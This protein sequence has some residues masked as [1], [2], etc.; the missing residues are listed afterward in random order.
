MQALIDA[1]GKGRFVE[2]SSPSK[3]E[4]LQQLAELIEGVDPRLREVDVLAAVTAREQTRKTGLGMGWACPHA[5]VPGDLPLVS[6]IGWS[7]AGIDYGSADG[8]KVHM[9]VMYV[10]PEAQKNSYLKDISTLAKRLWND[11]RF[12]F[13]DGI[14]DLD[15]MHRH[16]VELV[17]APYEPLRIDAC[18]RAPRDNEAPALRAPA[19]PVPSMLPLSVLSVPGVKSVVLALDR[20]LVTTLENTPDLGRTLDRHGQADVGGFRVLVRSHSK[21]AQDR[22]LYEC[23][24]IRSTAAPG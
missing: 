17:G 18:A 9:V 7:R 19:A 16:V 23:L 8:R 3:G 20:T 13:L 11:T 22:T 21:F 12:Q 15:E 10:V 5:H 14:G 24:A 4:A 6:A 1:L 2:L